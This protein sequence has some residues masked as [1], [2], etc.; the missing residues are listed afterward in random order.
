MPPVKRE[1][2]SLSDSH[3]RVHVRT[4]VCL[5]LLLSETAGITYG[6]SLIAS[7]QSVPLLSLTENK[8]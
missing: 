8:L 3:I 5:R 7:F 6:N 4:C 2:T 1:E